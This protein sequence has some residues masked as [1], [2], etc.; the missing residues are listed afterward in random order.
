MSIPIDLFIT[1]ALAQGGNQDHLQACLAHM[2]YCIVAEEQYNLAYFFVKRIKCARS[3]PTANLPYGIF[4]THL[5]RHIM[6]H[7]LHIDNGIYN[8][9]D[10]VMRPLDLRQTQNPK[11]IVEKPVTLSHP[12]PPIITV[13]LHL[14]K[15]MM[16]RMMVL[17]VLV[18]HLLPPT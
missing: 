10:R 12:H 2:L 16:M 9:V 17:L 6:E 11:V 5:Y 3:N 15:E 14:A 8:V 4:L 7:Y 1:H 13:D 18:P